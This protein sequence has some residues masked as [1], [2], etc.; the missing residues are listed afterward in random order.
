MSQFERLTIDDI[1]RL[2]NVSRTTASMVLNGYA[3]RYRISAATVERV[4]QVA[5]DNHFTPSQSARAL[6]SRRSNT[7]GLV[8]PD[9]TNSAHAALAQAME[10]LCRAQYGYQ[11]V[12]VTSDEDPSRE[13]EGIAHLVAH[14]VDGMIVVPCTADAKRYDKWIKRLPVVFADRRVDGSA[15]PYVVTDATETVATL[16]GD[17]LRQGIREV[18]YFGGQRELS[19]SRDRLAGYRQ[20]LAAH[21]LKEHE[22]WVFE[23][24]YQ[25]DSG[26]ALMQA[27]FDAHGR[28]PQALFAGSITLLEGVLSFISQTH[29]LTQAPERLMT[30]DDHQLLDCL[31]LTIDAIVQ[32]SH[33]LAEQSLRSVMAM[34][35]GDSDA[36]ESMRVPARIHYRRGG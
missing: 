14:Q 16:V 8:I 26:H 32:D 36:P 10:S 28:Y 18:V 9:L 13:T 35:D 22:D 30:F 17:A 12:T 11:L 27:W 6:R 34:L 20:A 4:L 33:Q 21:G 7:I 15:I 2:A 31:P 19:A 29:K 5:R 25:R 3:E 23:R 1:A 24:D